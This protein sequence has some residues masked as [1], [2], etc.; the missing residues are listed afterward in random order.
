MRSGLTFHN[1]GRN[2]KKGWH[3][4]YNK[5]KYFNLPFFSGIIDIFYDEA[6]DMY[7]P[8]PFRYT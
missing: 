5:L 8:F 1:S 7:A 4:R 3:V 2:G 6:S